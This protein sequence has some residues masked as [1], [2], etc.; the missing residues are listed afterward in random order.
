MTFKKVIGTFI[1]TDI[2]QSAKLWRKH[3]NKMSKAIEKHEKLVEKY[4][5]KNKG[6]IVKSIGDSFML[7][8][9]GKTSYNRALQFS[10]DFMKHIKNKPIKVGSSC[11]CF[12]IGG[13]YGKALEHAS[14]I[15]GKR[16]YDYFG[17]AV[18]LAARMESVVANR[19]EIAI[20]FYDQKLWKPKYIHDIRDYRKGCKIPKSR[21]RSERLVSSY[22]CFIPEKLKGAK[23]VKVFIFKDYGKK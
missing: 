21:K 12:R 16:L 8:F 22:S 9:R 11:L 20:S 14:K 3:N 7:F 6:M 18:N 13:S 5:K 23:P 19:G 17:N 4:A 1:F 10:I 15:Q 2:V